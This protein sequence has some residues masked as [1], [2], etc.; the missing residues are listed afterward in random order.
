MKLYSQ[1]GYGRER[2]EGMRSHALDAVRY[3][4]TLEKLMLFR[5]LITKIGV[6]RA[7]RQTLIAIAT[8]GTVWVY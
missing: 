5:L 6:M 2:T 4:T 3:K 8:R 1:K 7:L